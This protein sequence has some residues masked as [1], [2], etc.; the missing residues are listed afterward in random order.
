MATILKG[1]EVVEEL[2]LKLRNE[3]KELR[4]KNIIPTLGIIRIGEN[5]SD[6]AYESHVERKSKLLETQLKKIL[7]PEDATQEQLIEKIHEFNN[8][9]GVHGILLFR[10][11]PLYMDDNVVRNEMLPKKDID[12]IT[13]KSMA[14]IYSNATE[15][16]LP[17]TA[18]ACVDILKYYNIPIEGKKIVVVGRSLV[19]GK[20]VSMMLLNLNATVTICH[21][22]TKD[23]PTICRNSDIIIAAMGKAK[24]ISTECFN[25]NHVIIDVGINTNAAGLV[26]GDVDFDSAVH[27]VKAI[28]PTPGGVGTVTT[29]VLFKHLVNAAQKSLE[30]VNLNI[31]RSGARD[32]LLK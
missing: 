24:T 1:K 4:E 17:C 12:G 10:P 15:G 32:V 30:R 14:A 2:N 20:P 31:E 28:T 26:Y 21:S 18:E 7:L 29:G 9:N 16:Y 11:I 19:I 22:R 23:L 5:L 8:D 27:V 13:D 3:I 25:T 6:L